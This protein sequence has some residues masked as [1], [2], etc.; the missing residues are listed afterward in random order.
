MQLRSK[1]EDGCF[2]LSAQAAMEG[3]SAWMTAQGDEGCGF[4]VLNRQGGW[5]V[6]V[7]ISPGAMFRGYVCDCGEY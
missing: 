5:I 4:M 6:K 7:L 1:L 2:F 3:A